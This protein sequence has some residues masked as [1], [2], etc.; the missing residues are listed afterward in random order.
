MILLGVAMCVPTTA[1]SAAEP[2]TTTTIEQEGGVELDPYL[3]DESL[4]IDNQT[5][6]GVRPDGLER[7]PATP[8]ADG[9]YFWVEPDGDNFKTLFD[10]YSKTHRVSAK[11]YYGTIYRSAWV[12]AGGRASISIYA[13]SWGCESYWSTI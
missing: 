1:V 13:T 2:D 10:H 5:I 9:G 3:Q 8:N 7:R 4:W 11:N 6:Y 12:G